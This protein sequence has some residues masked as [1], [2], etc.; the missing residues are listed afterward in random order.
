[1]K[2]ISWRIENLSRGF[3]VASLALTVIQAGLVLRFAPELPPQIPLFYSLTWGEPRL[4]APIYLWLL[5]GL[6]LLILLFN[7]AVSALVDLPILTRIM[8]I[9]S[10]LVSLFTIITV[11]KIILLGLP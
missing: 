10:F 7:F 1:M 11:G 6:S 3:V 2:L 5:P 9:T 4:G 8:S